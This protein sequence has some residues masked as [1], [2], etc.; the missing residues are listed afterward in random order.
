M[1][2]VLSMLAEIGGTILL[3]IFDRGVS[4][5]IEW[6]CWE[7][8]MFYFLSLEIFWSMVEAGQPETCE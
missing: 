2:I 1:F 8:I 7:L 6:Y 4:S 5:Q 3:N